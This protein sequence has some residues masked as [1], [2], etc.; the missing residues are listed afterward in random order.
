MVPGGGAGYVVCHIR[1]GLQETGWDPEG[2]M[3]VRVPDPFEGVFHIQLGTEDVFLQEGLG[4]VRKRVARDVE[5]EQVGEGSRENLFCITV[6]QEGKLILL[7][8]RFDECV[9]ISTKSVK[10]LWMVVEQVVQDATFDSGVHDE[11]E[12][13]NAVKSRCRSKTH[14]VKKMT[15]L[16][17]QFRSDLDPLQ[18]WFKQVICLY[19]YAEQ[20]GWG[21]DLE[22]RG[23]VG[24]KRINKRV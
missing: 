23:E 10:M 13:H 4:E 7:P 17:R 11:V 9:F 6:V 19:I 1:Q 20:G 24:G 15:L 14:M 18:V 16:I 8:L 5:V 22:G 21:M 2:E 12:F 3:L